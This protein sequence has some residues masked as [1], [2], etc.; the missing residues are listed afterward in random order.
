MTSATK[1]LG[2]G[3]VREDRELEAWRCFLRAHAAITRRLDSE[4]TAAHELTLSQ[5]EVLL[6]LSEAPD[7]KMRMSELAKRVLL[8]RSGVTRLISGLEAAELVE[9][10]TCAADARGA[11]ARLTGPGEAKLREASGTHRQGVEELYLGRFSKREL[12]KLSE[13]L[14]ALPGGSAATGFVD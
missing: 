14:S 4:L 12:E 1:E 8:T 11:F 3:A 5:Y 9:R 6:H 7:R 10:T 13:L 2:G